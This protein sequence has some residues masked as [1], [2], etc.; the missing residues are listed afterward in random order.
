[1]KPRATKK[2]SPFRA[3]HMRHLNSSRWS[4]KLIRVSL[5]KSSPYCGW[6]LEL[7]G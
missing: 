1:M 6:E 4:P 3:D 7:M 5:N 2:N